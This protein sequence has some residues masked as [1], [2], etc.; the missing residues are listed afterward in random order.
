MKLS[1]GLARSNGSMVERIDRTVDELLTTE[2]GWQ[3]ITLHGLDGEG[4]KPIR[5][6]YLDRLLKR[7][8]T[9]ETLDILPPI[10]A[11]AKYTSSD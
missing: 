11:F 4:W 1:S 3:V 7:L 8:S 6:D 2:S 5:S 9:I 10:R